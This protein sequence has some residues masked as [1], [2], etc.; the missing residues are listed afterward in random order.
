MSLKIVYGSSLSKKTEY[1]YDWIIKEAEQAPEKQFILLVPE[2][3]S[4]S[5]QEQMI[6]RHRDHAFMN[7][8]I[9][10]FNRLSYH[11]FE[12]TGEKEKQIL[13]ETGK[14]M[15][16]R[17]AAV[18]T[19]DRLGILKRNLK[20][21]G[22]LDELKSV[23]SELAE[24]NITPQILKERME[25]LKDR[26]YLYR[27][28]CD[29]SV[30]Y[31]EFMRLLHENYEMA[32]ERT[33][34]LSSCIG[35]WKQAENTVF[36]LDGFTGFTPPQ[37]DVLRELFRKCP[38]IAVGITVGSGRTAEENRET[39][40]LFY[41]GAHMAAGLKTMAIMQSLP[42]EE[43]TVTEEDPCSP[44][45]RHLERN[46]YVSPRRP[47]EGS[48][49]NIRLFRARNPKAE[50]RCVLADIRRCVRAGYTYRQMAV[51]TGDP[52]QYRGEIEAA[53]TEAEIP[54]FPDEVRPMSGNPLI[55]WI[56]DLLN[57]RENG[58]S[59]EGLFSVLKNPLT[60]RFVEKQLE[61]ENRN[62]APSA[63]TEKAL[64]EENAGAAAPVYEAEDQKTET[65]AE[66]TAYER[67]CEA[68]NY[69]EA[70]GL[71]GSGV[72]EREWQILLKGMTEKD[73]ASLNGLRQTL[74]ALFDDTGVLFKEKEAGTADRTQALKALLE[75][76]EIP[77]GML[78]LS[79][80]TEDPLL[81]KEY[82]EAVR[83]VSELLEETEAILGGQELTGEAFC[84]VL[85]SGLDSLKLGMVPP[86]KDRI[87]VGDLLRTRL[88]GIRKLYV[89]GANEG[90]LPPVAAEN[91]LLSDSEREI[92]RTC[93]LELSPGAKEE[94]FYYRFYLYLL[95]TKPSE[96]LFMT[97]S[98]SGNDGKALSPSPLIGTLT[99]L[100]PGLRA[101]DRTENAPEDLST[102]RQGL[103]DLADGLRERRKE[104]L[105]EESLYGWFLENAPEELEKVLKGALYR[106]IPE[107]LSEEVCDRM[108]RESVSGSVTRLEQF[109]GCAYAHFLSYGL[110]LREKEE[111]ELQSRDY[112]NIYHDS[113]NRFFTLLKKDREN[114]LDLDPEREKALVEESVKEVTEEYGNAI[115]KD[116]AR[117][118][119]LIRRVERLTKRTIWALKKQWEAGMFTE[120]ETEVP[121]RGQGGNDALVLP[122]RDG[123]DL[124][125]EGRIDRLD[126]AETG[127]S[128][129]L[130]VIDYKSSGR[131]IDLTKVWY[132]L[133]LQ[134]LLYMEAAAA[135]EQKKNPDREVIPAGAYY[136]HVDDP[137]VEAA[138]PADADKKIYS[139]LKMRGLT[140]AAENVRHLVDRNADAGSEVVAGLKLKK[141]GTFANG[142]K[143]ADTESLRKLGHFALEKA[144]ELAE[145][146]SD[147]DIR[148]N[149][150]S[151]Q[152]KDACTWCAYQGICGFDARIS[153]YE[154]RRL[155]KKTMDELIGKQENGD[156]GV[157]S[158]T[159]KGN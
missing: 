140:N 107:T 92:L 134:L 39:D 100:F 129:Y 73:L 48:V 31:E 125:L 123:R 33:A 14:R 38:E 148:V 66:L 155:T 37:Y 65:E 146:V 16:L 34:R 68:E 21:E 40:D 152:N 60:V 133:Q 59:C 42:V 115:L 62:A 51:I 109:A 44:E 137:L 41:M 108:F 36:A 89:L 138:D 87:V 49:E 23:I 70:L 67:I 11:V 86:S 84:D 10:T 149:P 94:S 25:K 104:E 53:F 132:G 6:R 112:G 130:K 99:G 18:R 144:R 103:D 1:L 5:A 97:Y 72:F 102:V 7:I 45:I 69:A 35:R 158:G 54:Y 101:E 121:F 131:D 15:L 52:E 147:G 81:K 29:I 98:L 153:G 47:Y 142:A 90:L 85:R 56:E 80:S 76:A 58:F 26:P 113:L 22:F 8:D 17:L 124:R 141:D 157:D 154:K 9:L 96:S 135:I 88:S 61:A 93:D 30:L 28:L 159:E 71:R 128:I 110:K 120:T 77:E 19:E 78:F 4:L 13:D 95:L 64:R 139:A 151:Y 74:S 82:E 83:I 145:G 119:Y 126:R 75:K 20:K 150:Y 114:W 24:Y 55:R 50:V 111:R 116:S 156:H 118:E 91:G 122:L 79:E 12:E 46:L 63:D 105:C 117:N 136:Y 143:T 3:A 127:D 27:K 2:Q 43:I 57:L 32:E 106:Y